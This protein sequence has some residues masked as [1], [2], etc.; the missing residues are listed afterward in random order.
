MDVARAQ[1]RRPLQQ[2]QQLPTANLL[3][4]TDR[5]QV[6]LLVEV[7]PASQECLECLEWFLGRLTVLSEISQL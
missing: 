6:R 3:E 2:P 7:I 4:V 1:L 5:V